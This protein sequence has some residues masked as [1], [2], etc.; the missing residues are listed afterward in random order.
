MMYPARPSGFISHTSGCARKLILS[1]DD[2]RA[3]LHTREILLTCAGYE[4]LSA[5]QG[6]EA[7][8]MVANHPVDLVLL[9]YIMPGLDG[10]VVAREIKKV[11]PHV[12]V[13]LISA[14]DISNETMEC[15][16]ALMEK[17]RGP[18]ALLKKISEFL[19]SAA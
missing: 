13:I 3:I 12:P 5:I 17:G 10:G 1:V 19:Q 6:I 18:A 16:D 9:D 4:V 11:R 8:E 2:E 15:V 7:L 14:S